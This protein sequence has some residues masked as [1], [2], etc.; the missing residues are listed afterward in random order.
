MGGGKWLDDMMMINWATW[1]KERALSLPYRLKMPKGSACTS[2]VTV[3]AYST[4]VPI[5][6]IHFSHSTLAHL[7]VLQCY[8]SLL[9]IIVALT[10][11][12]SANTVFTQ[13]VSF[14]HQPQI[15]TIDTQNF[16]Q[17]TRSPPQQQRKKTRQDRVRALCTHINQLLGRRTRN[18]PIPN[19]IT[20]NRH[21]I[22]QL[23]ACSRSA[24][25]TNVCLQINHAS[26][27]LSYNYLTQ[28]YVNSAGWMHGWTDGK[29][30]YIL[31]P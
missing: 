4:V 6:I 22:P 18:I 30:P 31:H 29:L 17:P 14:H 16:P 15:N 13:S 24:R 7:A 21:I 26:A 1:H 11:P 8:K 23:R 19:P 20:Q 28:F 27:Y 25:D 5:C 9:L 3:S 12:S 2:I 10:S